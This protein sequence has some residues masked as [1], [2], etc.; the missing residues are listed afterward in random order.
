[1]MIIV[2]GAMLMIVFMIA[3]IENSKFLKCPSLDWECIV[4]DE[5]LTVV[6]NGCLQK[7]EEWEYYYNI[8]LIY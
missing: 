8:Y 1:M 2:A 3:F 4:D 5:I 6:V 7:T